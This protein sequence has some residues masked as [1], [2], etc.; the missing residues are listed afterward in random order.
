MKKTLFVAMCAGLLSTAFVTTAAQAAAP[1]VFGQVGARVI[2]QDTFDRQ[3]QA[4]DLRLGFKGAGKFG[5]VTALYQF[6]LDYTQAS[7]DGGG[8]SDGNDE[9]QVR[10]ARLLF[11]TQY[12]TF[13]IAPKSPSSQFSILYGAVDIFE[14]NGAN[15]D[16][17]VSQIFD[18]GQTSTHVLAWA[19]PRK[20]GFKGL[21]SYLTGNENND[22]DGDYM[23]W[24]LDWE[25]NKDGALKGLRAAVGQVY[26]DEKAIHAAATEQ[27][28]RTAATF[29]YKTGGF[30]VGAT[31]ENYDFD[32]FGNLDRTNTGVV[33]SYTY[34]GYTLGVGQFDRDFDAA[35]MDAADNKGTVVSLKKQFDKNLLM[36]IENGDFD[37][38]GQSS[39]SFGA[40]LKF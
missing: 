2:D 22:V 17:G 1:T 16:N 38:D 27:A 37:I 14:T 34:N 35:A 26:V 3:V 31:H 12:G 40:K 28:V 23:T 10:N 6:A 18:Q 19:S 24:W 21:L 33:A 30:Y 15:A 29:G 20:A 13:V 4:Y 5:G 36:F 25:G 8:T 9:V 11:P 39:L 32:G 7:N